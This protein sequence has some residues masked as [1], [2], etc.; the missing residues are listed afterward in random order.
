MKNAKI[1]VQ[2]KPV[3]RPFLIGKQKV[4]ELLQVNRRFRVGAPSNSLAHSSRTQAVVV[5][6]A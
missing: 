5:R 1:I 6:D 2:L 4:T 3:Y